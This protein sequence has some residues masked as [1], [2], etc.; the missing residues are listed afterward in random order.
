MRVAR[1]VP[2]R[3]PAK[4]V[5]SSGDRFARRVEVAIRSATT[6]LELSSPVQHLDL[7]QYPPVM[8]PTIL[9]NADWD[10]KDFK[11]LSATVANAFAIAGQID[12][13][14]R[15]NFEEMMDHCNANRG[16]LRYS[17]GSRNNLPH[18]VIAKAP[19]SYNCVAQNV[20]YTQDGNVSKDL[21]FKV[22]D[23]AFVNVGNYQSD[24]D[25]ARIPLVLSDPPC[26]PEVQHR[27]CWESAPVARHPANRPDNGYSPC[28]QD[29]RVSCPRATVI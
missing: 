17:S 29:R 20:P 10:F 26:R 14:R 9:W 2:A 27:L 8:A 4:A 13:T 12:E 16:E 22:L 18:M 21:V 24:P 25:K 7:A 3:S 1:T 6:K 11:P 19:Q 5:I 15:S 28:A 23:F